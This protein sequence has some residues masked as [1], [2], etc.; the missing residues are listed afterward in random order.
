[1]C[2]AADGNAI[3][4]NSPDSIREFSDS[5]ENRDDSVLGGIDPKTFRPRFFRYRMSKTCVKDL[6]VKLTEI[7]ELATSKVKLNDISN[8]SNKFKVK[9]FIKNMKI[10]LKKAST[11][12]TYH[13]LFLSLLF[14]ADSINRKKRKKC[15]RILL[16]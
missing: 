3:L 11:Y 6:P 5:I 2:S 8:V 1:M 10:L 12:Q 4:D 15:H 16:R 13:F 7:Y 9:R 14:T